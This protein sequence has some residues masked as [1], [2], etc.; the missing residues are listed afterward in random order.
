MKLP[1]AANDPERFRRRYDWL[2]A[3]A[4]ERWVQWRC[5]KIADYYGEAARV[6]RSH[7]PD[8]QLVLSMWVPSVA[9]PDV[10]TGW[11][12]GERLMVQ[13]REEG[14]DPALLGQISGVVIQEFMSA[15]D[16]PWRLALAGLKEEKNLPPIREADFR[17]DQ[18]KDYQTTGQFGVYFHNRYFENGFRRKAI[19]GKPVKSGWYRE[20]PWL[21]SAVVP[22]HDHFMEYYAHAMAV[23]DPSLITIGGWT[24]GTVGHETQVER[25]ARVFRL[26]PQGK[27]RTIPALGEQIVGRMLDKDGKRYVY[28][29][30]RPPAEARVALN[31]SVAPGNMQPLGSSPALTS[32]GKGRDVVL[33]AYQLAAWT[34]E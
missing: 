20:P 2:M 26:L 6:L 8:I 19:D 32:T 29:V 25:F 24:V 10:R 11:E 17:K 15:T 12:Q 28:L 33:E 4:K 7:R 14:V 16:Y 34:S 27:W 22:G 21:A 1:V 31:D 5:E 23:F 3:N 30:N 13:T 18:L 9:I